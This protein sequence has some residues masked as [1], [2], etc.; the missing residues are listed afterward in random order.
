[1]FSDACGLWWKTFL[2]LAYTSGGRRD[3]LINLTWAD[4]DFEKHNVRFVPKQDSE[5]LLAWE[6]KD[7]QMREV[8]I[9]SE[10]V[11]LLVNLQLEAEET[12]PYVFITKARL[13]HILNRRTKGSWQPDS[14][15]VHNLIRDLKVLCRRVGVNSF[16][17]HDL[18][19]SC[20][21]NWARGL[22]I[23]TVQYLAGHSSIETKRKY[24]LSVQQSD[25]DLARRLQSKVMTSL[26][27]FGLKSPILGHVTKKLP[28]VSV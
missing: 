3:E 7:H 18:R 12:S 15:I 28:N 14:E 26:T 8:P 9:P 20:I 11:K 2:A 24:Y 25:L 4:V 22:P 21:T 13:S 19:R 10:T 5:S 17:L 16:T 6:P 27:N 1:M 23:Q